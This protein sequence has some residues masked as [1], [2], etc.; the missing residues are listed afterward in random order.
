MR[1]R[2][3]MGDFMVSNQRYGRTLA[4]F[5]PTNAA[6]LPVHYDP[7][8]DSYLYGQDRSGHPRSLALTKLERARR[9]YD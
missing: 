6:S 8:F 2:G 4:D 3:H 9:H 5:L 7:D 1:R